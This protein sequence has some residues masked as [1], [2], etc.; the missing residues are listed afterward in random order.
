MNLWF[1]DES[2]SLGLRDKSLSLGF[3]DNSCSKP[4]V[5]VLRV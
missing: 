4:G 5:G 3:S 1:R 2:L